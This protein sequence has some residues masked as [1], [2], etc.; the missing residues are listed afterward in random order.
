MPLLPG[1]VQPEVLTGS[2]ISG[3]N[4]AAIYEVN[5]V[6]P[7]A[8]LRF[9]NVPQADERGKLLTLRNPSGLAAPELGSVT[10]H[11]ELVGTTYH[12]VSDSGETVFFTA[13]PEASEA[14]TVY[15]RVPC[16]SASYEFPV[17]K[18][19]TVGGGEGRET[20]KVSDPSAGEGCAACE[21]A[22][23][24]EVRNVTTKTEST[25]VEATGGF[26][27]VMTGMVVEGAGI[28]TGT[29][30]SS[31]SPTKLVLSAAV[32]EGATG[33]TLMF[34]KEEHKPAAFVGASADGSKVFFT[35]KQKLLPNGASTPNL[36][37]YDFN[38]NLPAYMNGQRLVD[39]SPDPS[40]AAVLG[41]VRGSSD[42]SHVYFIAEGVLTG[43]ANEY[44]KTAEAG[45][46]N[47]YGVDTETGQI[48][49]IAVVSG[50]EHAEGGN[51]FPHSPRAQTTPDGLDLVFSSTA[52]LAGSTNSGSDSV[53]RYDF[54]TGS[55]TWV[56]HD[57]PG[58]TAPSED[59]NAYVAVIP[60]F[61][62]GAFSDIDD[63]NRAISGEAD[64]AHDG[65]DLIFT[66]VER[67]ATGEQSGGVQLYLWHCASPCPKPNEEGVVQMIS[68]GR[69]NVEPNLRN[70]GTGQDAT[71]AMSASGADI[72]FS[73]GTR[74]VGQDTDEL[75]DYYDARIDGGYPAPVPE[76]TCTGE[77][78]Q[79]PTG[80]GLGSFEPAASSLLSAGGNLGPPVSA[81]LAFQTSTPKPLTR[82]QKLA[83]ALKACSKKRSKKNRVLCQRQARKQYASKAAAKK[84]R[85]AN[86]KSL[87]RG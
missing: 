12:A 24:K 80:S 71:T 13:S 61:I 46:E 67:L 65:E 11:V 33:V 40:G 64:G 85:R 82:A 21:D 60:G 54:E 18:C 47:L 53:Y 58:F 72:F 84:A 51:S 34:P 62:L 49:F 15:A 74:L 4:T 22:E 73:T 39:L 78:C 68:D 28:P 56:S 69:S 55:L 9:V 5:H 3:Y 66:T 25:A 42:G 26:P 20:V 77:A 14:E 50:L 38:K 32:T 79:P 70:K 81:A 52:Q 48:R 1:D 19:E 43:E 75:L 30:V 6:G 37:E 86:T 7:T 44:G 31:V 10:P 2:T 27:G 76:P 36:Y 83:K 87:H 45:K 8:Q 59:K 41:V 57:A 63:F 16:P 17:L 35:T 23:P 29:K